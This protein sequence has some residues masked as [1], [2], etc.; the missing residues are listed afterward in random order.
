MAG[1]GHLYVTMHGVWNAA[2]WVPETAQIGVRLLNR[3]LGDPSG[4]IVPVVD[5]GGVVLASNQRDLTD[6]NVVQTFSAEVPGV[7]AASWTEF[8]DD[9][10]N[11]CKTFMAA[12]KS[13]QHTGYR[14]THVKIAPIEVGTGK[15]LA[16]ATTY[17]LKAPIAGTGATAMPPQDAICA[18]L[19]ANVVGRRGRGRI[20]L[21]GLAVGTLSADGK[22]GSSA[23]TT[24]ANAFSDLVADLEDLPGTDL[25]QVRVAVMSANSTQAVLPSEV[26]VG[27]QFDTQRRREEQV[28]EA[29][30]SVQL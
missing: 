27:D 29:Y 6:W 22:V 16:P 23:R 9:L 26:R 4:P 20:Y 1:Y 10:A 21:P 12:V 11:D 14:W 17:T 25:W 3:Q 30:T 19:R 15:Y 7:P 5:R 13:L 18:S 2:A 8:T 28:G 24:L